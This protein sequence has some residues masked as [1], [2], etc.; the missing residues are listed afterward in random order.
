[1]LVYLIIS[2]SYKIPKSRSWLPIIAT[3]TL[4][5]LKGSNI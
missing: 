3:S 2:E 5:K 1:V 4:H